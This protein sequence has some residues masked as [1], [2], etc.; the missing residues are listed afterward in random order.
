MSNLPHQASRTLVYP[1]FGSPRPAGPSSIRIYE[2][3]TWTVFEVTGEFGW[4]ITRGLR[5]LL[6]TASSE[7]VVLDLCGVPF[8]DHN[9]LAV[10]ARAHRAHRA[11]GG[12][13]RLV[14][15]PQ[16]VHTLLRMARGSDLPAVFTTVE[17]ATA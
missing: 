10:V 1:A 15:P 3:G 6:R 12:A 13:V 4:S 5:D 2:S 17:E 16:S 7:R 8:V 9:S 14:E 11:L